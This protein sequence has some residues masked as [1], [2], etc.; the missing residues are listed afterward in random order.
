MI[1]KATIDDV[2]E[3]AYVINISNYCAYKNIIPREFFKHPVVNRDKILE[4]MKRMEFYVY[5]INNRIV[6]VAALY[7]RYEEDRGIVRWV[8]VHPE[9]Q[10]RGI[11]TVLMKY[12]EGKARRLGLRKLQL[13]THEKAYWAIKFYEK[14]GFKVVNY[15]ERIAWRDVLME[16][17]LEQK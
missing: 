7:P 9:Y 5:E 16:K 8:Y 12:I 17:I 15:I 10:R 11:G 3:V 13:I 2:N 1:R 14:L 6:G 4:D